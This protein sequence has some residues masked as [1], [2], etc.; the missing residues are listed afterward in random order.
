MSISASM[1]QELR[2]LTGAG[3][4]ECKDAL[5]EASGDIQGALENLKKK[6][7][8]KAVKKASRSTKAGL[9]AILQSESA[10]SI[11]ELKCETD[12]V[13]RN[14]KFQEL[15]S[16]I[17]KSRLE[18][19]DGSSELLPIST[20]DS[21]TVKEKIEGMIQIVGENIT[22][23]RAERTALKGSGLFGSYVHG[24]G[25][26]GVLV[27]I[28][29]ENDASSNPLYGDV[30]KNIAMHIA[31]SSPLAVSEDEIADEIIKQ[32][33]RI[34]EEQ[35]VESGKPSKIIPQ[36]VKGKLNKYFS[37]VTLLKQPYVKDPD[38]RVESY[39]KDVSAELGD[40][41]VV[42]SFLR[43]QLGE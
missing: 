15:A 23:G 3:I 36:I 32:E 33:T 35:A 38:K 22:L 34:F 27:E 7:A 25:S 12:F 24:G 28:G 8:L 5:K 17:A 14:D 18:N 41:L 10:A 2:E 42:R 19:A 30:A 29:I 13:S 40:K 43:Y 6:G 1:V 39:L 9:I 21:Q 26:I 31:A 37:E 11:V 20:T 16:M 4:M